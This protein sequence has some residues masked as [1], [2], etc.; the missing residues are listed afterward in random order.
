MCL[1]RGL[2]STSILLVVGACAST[3]FGR[4]FDEKRVAEIKS[5]VTTKAEVQSMLGQPLSRMRIDGKE[6]WTYQRGSA[7]AGVTGA[8]A[9]KSGAATVGAFALGMIPVVGMIALPAASAAG[10]AAGA[11]EMS[12]KSQSK[13][14]QL[15]FDITDR[16]S[17]CRLTVNSSNTIMP[18]GGDTDITTCGQ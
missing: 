17:S 5:G 12:S 18:M 6:S 9:A 2:I 15:D 13:T 1:L 11:G 4:E 8:G 10:S 16:V 3:E 7:S 14:L